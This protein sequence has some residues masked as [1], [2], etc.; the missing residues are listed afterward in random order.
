MIYSKISVENPHDLKYI[1]EPKE[2][3]I[4]KYHPFLFSDDSDKWQI[5]MKQYFK[6]SLVYGVSNK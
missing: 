1:S 2:N 3:R 6:V 4:K 5:G